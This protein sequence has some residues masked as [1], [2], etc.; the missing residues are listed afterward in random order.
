MTNLRWKSPWRLLGPLL[1]LLVVFAPSCLVAQDEKA[2]SPEKREEFLVTFKRGPLN[3][4]YDDGVFLRLMVEMSKATS[5]VEVGAYNGYSAIH[6]GIAFERNGGKLTT[7]DIDP[8]AVEVS[9]ANIAKF[10]LDKTITVV[11]GDALKVLPELKGEYDYVF[12][13]AVKSDTLKYF[14]AIKP[15]LKVGAVIVVHNAVSS[16][17][18]MK[19]FLDA[20]KADKDYDMVIVRAGTNPRDGMAICYRRK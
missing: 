9:R 12:I 14:Q 1:G 13:D 20:M 4:Q 19:D 17:A 18:A 3:V 8:K 10:G 11:E 5:G 16:A 6:A 7:I 2:V 15:R